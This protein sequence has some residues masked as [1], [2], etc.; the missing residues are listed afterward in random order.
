M[1]PLRMQSA[2][3]QAGVSLVELMIGITIGLF[4]L[5]GVVSV[6][7]NSNRV[8][9][10]LNQAS[11]QIENG[12]FAVQM[13]ADDVAHAGFYGRYYGALPVPGVL[14]DP[15]EKTDMAVLRTGAALHIQ[16][17]NAPASSPIT[18]CLPVANH[19]AGTDIL[20]VR[21]ADSTVTASGSLT[22]AQV[23]VQ[24]NADPNE[25]LNPIIKL[26]AA[27]NFTLLNR[28][29]TT[30][31]PIR[32]YHVHIY[33]I[34]PCSVP[35]GGGTVCTGATDDG[36][37]PIPTLKRLELTL[38][39]GGA[40]DMVL[41]PLVEGIE[42]LQIDYGIDTD[43]DGAP[44]GDYV[45][46]PASIADWQNVVAV[47]LNV[48]ARNVEPSG[49]YTDAKQYDMGVVGLITPGGNYKRHVY[50]AVVRVINPSARRDS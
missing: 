26:G 19:L 32:K 30:L 12:R 27:A 15:C 16:G 31:A 23:Y 17:Y 38:D 24:T 47:R 14:P 36:G 4:L 7:G 29:A 3:R 20:V 8:Y 37:R 6:F 43:A 21:R 10:E 50:N 22:A 44:N 42:N 33:F 39:S 48:L 2:A 11:Q 34:A 9:T 5:I 46:T 35:A 40:L 41:T 45:V 1:N 13:V 25:S 18:G 28:D 49:G